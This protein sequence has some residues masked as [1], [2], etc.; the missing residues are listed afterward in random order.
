MKKP[1]NELACQ[2]LFLQ[3]AEDGRGKT[4]FGED[5]RNTCQGVIPFVTGVPFPMLYLEFPLCGDP[6]LACTVTVI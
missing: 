5:W 1:S 6:F 3:A 4:L 2:A